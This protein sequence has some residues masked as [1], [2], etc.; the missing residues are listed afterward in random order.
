MN[1]GG[2]TFIAVA[3]SLEVQVRELAAS[4]GIADVELRRSTRRRSTVSAFRESGRV[5]ISAPAR[6]SSEEL[7][8][9]AQELLMR[10]IKQAQG[11]TPTDEQLMQRARRLTKQ[12]LPTGFPEP[13][14]VRWTS[15][16]SRVW[17]TCVNSEG[18]IRLSHRLR[19]MPDFVV[20][21]VLLHELAHLMQHDHGPEFE[22]LLANFPERE[23]AR[24]FL[25]GVTWQSQQG[26]TDYLAAQ[27]MDLFNAD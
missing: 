17:G 26:S 4:L 1:P 21:Y 16:Q 7:L 9:L 27:Q 2:T 3:R 19:A 6:I 5:V 14:S 12:W 25:D 23:R 24:G 10:L 22:A 15:A 20:D 13:S 8:P 18:S 11:R